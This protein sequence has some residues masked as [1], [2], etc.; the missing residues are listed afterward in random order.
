MPTSTMSKHTAN[1]WESRYNSKCESLK[2]V[3]LKMEARDNEIQVL[4][5]TVG[6]VNDNVSKAMQRVRNKKRKL[7]E[8]AEAKDDADTIVQAHEATIVELQDTVKT[9]DTCIQAQEQAA[10]ELRDNLNAEKSLVVQLKKDQ[11]LFRKKFRSGNQLSDDKLREQLRKRSKASR[12]WSLM[13]PKDFDDL[14]SSMFTGCKA[15]WRLANFMK[16]QCVSYK[17][18]GKCTD[19]KEELVQEMVS[20]VGFSQRA[21]KRQRKE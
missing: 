13:P 3:T 9:L 10:R 20:M 17:I 21:R 12:E 6:V 11:T 2:R 14:H 18:N 19:R 1:Y 5:K 4:R 16:P 8:L 7:K 15:E